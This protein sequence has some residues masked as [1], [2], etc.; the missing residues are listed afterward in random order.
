MVEGKDLEIKALVNKKADIE[1][2]K[3]AIK[4]LEGKMKEIYNY[5]KAEEDK[6]KSKKEYYL[7]KK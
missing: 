5:V 6:A 1:D 7:G 2:F 3:K 4:Y